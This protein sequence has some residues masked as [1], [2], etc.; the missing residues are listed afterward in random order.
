MRN[1]RLVVSGCVAVVLMGPVIFAGPGQTPT[2]ER[3]TGTPA[4]IIKVRV[5][6][7]PDEVLPV[8]VRELSN[9]NNPLRVEIDPNT[10][11]HLDPATV[12]RAQIEPP[13]WEYK[14][15]Q[16]TANMDAA[17]QALNAEGAQGWEFASVMFSTPNSAVV[18]LKRMR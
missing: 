11:V 9:R 3:W 16:V 4:D 8:S 1:F 17:Q 14:V 2:Q 7:S 12:I 13:K 15:V 10:R 6:N 18:A 5:V